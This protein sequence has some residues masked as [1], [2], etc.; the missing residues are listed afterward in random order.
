MAAFICGSDAL[1]L[2]NLMMF[3]SG[4]FASLPSSNK[5]SLTR[6]SSERYSGKRAKILPDNEMSRLSTF[7]F[8]GA[9]N[10]LIIGKNECVAKKGDSSVLVYMIFVEFVIEFVFFE[11]GIYR[12]CKF[13]RDAKITIWLS[14]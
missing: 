1:I 6:W 2:G 11:I 14:K 7:T 4:D 5:A 8:A 10:A 13:L 3:A 12:F 9:V